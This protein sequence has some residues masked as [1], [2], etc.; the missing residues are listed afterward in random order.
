M[1]EKEVSDELLRE[2]ACPN[3]Q[4]PIDIRAHGQ[5]VVCDACSSR[6]IL[7]GHLCPQCNSYH[8]QERTFCGKCGAQM[9][10][11]CRRCLHQNWAGDEYCASCGQPM[12]IFDLLAQQHREVRDQQLPER[13]AQIRALK[14]QEGAAAEARMA[15][16]KAIAEA[17]DREQEARR[18][19]RQKQ[20]RLV[21]LVATSALFFFLVVL[22]VIV[23]VI[24]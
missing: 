16:L 9:Q 20:E 12:D 23:L 13:H 18:Q 4:N 1:E 8:E 22:G 24:L 2:V 6:F 5:H 11:V 17:Y 7:Y 15:E 10:R 3:C 19:A 21:M 14:Q